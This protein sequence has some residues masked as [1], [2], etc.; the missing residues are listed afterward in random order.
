MK[1]DE[2]TIKHPESAVRKMFLQQWQ[3]RWAKCVAA[4]ENYAEDN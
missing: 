3:K 2:D 4:E 1:F